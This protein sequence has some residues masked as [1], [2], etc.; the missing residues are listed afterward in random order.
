MHCK[1][2]LPPPDPQDQTIIC[3][4]SV[5]ERPIP[6]SHKCDTCSGVKSNLI[7]ADVTIDIRFNDSC[8]DKDYIKE[9]IGKSIAKVYERRHRCDSP[10]C[11][12]KF[13]NETSVRFHR[14]PGFSSIF[15]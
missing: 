6:T 2:H 10:E 12:R 9:R 14:K 8:V 4:V 1:V 15:S 3:D 11:I 13:D 5:V 7:Q